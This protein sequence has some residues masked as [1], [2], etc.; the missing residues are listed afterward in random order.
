VTVK[1]EART[2]TVTLEVELERKAGPFVSFPALAD[3]VYR[4]LIEAD[5]GTFIL[6]GSTYAVTTWT[7]TSIATGP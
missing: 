1:S 6:N 7:P 2:M 4:H 5:P 3:M